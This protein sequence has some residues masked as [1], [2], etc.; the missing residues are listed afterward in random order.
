LHEKLQG[1]IKEVSENDFDTFLGEQSMT[2]EQRLEENKDVFKRLK[3][4]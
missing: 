4:R 3:D 2:L 1:Y